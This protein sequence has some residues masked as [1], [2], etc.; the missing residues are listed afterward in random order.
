MVKLPTTER[1]VR[2]LL[3]RVPGIRELLETEDRRQ[4]QALERDQLVAE[5]AHLDARHEAIVAETMDVDQARQELIDAILQAYTR[6]HERLT[7]FMERTSPVEARR[8]RLQGQLRASAAPRLRAVE[9]RLRE[10]RDHV[11]THLPLA[12]SQYREAAR[13][14]R[15]QGYRSAGPSEADRQLGVLEGAIALADQAAPIRAAFERALLEVDGL[16]FVPSSELDA[17][18]QALLQSLPARCACG[19]PLLGNPATPPAPATAPVNTSD[20]PIADYTG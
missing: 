10:A 2:A 5:L 18:V 16:H 1:D 4:Q 19:S 9:H 3:E 13:D 7:A 11:A 15:D 8:S 12:L 6:F 17:R 20:A 14:L